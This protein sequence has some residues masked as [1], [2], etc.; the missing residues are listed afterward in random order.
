MGNAIFR[1]H[2]QVHLP[3]LTM[4]LVTLI[5][6]W[7]DFGL[8]FGLW[9][10]PRLGYKGLAWATFASVS[11]GA[12]LNLLIL[13]KQRR[14]DLG[15][16]PNRRWTRRGLPYLLRVAWP[17]GVQQILWHSGYLVVYALTASLP[18]GNIVAL[19]A[20]TAGL[21]LESLLFLPAFAFSMTASIL[22]GHHLGSLD[23]QGARGVA[24]RTWAI[25]CG[26]LTAL[27]AALWPTIPELAAL[28]APQEAVKAVTITY[29]RLNFLALPFTATGMILGGVFNGAGATKYNMQVIG[30]SIWLVRIPCAFV[31]G[32]L[33]LGTATGI[34][35]AMLISQTLQAL[36]MLYLFW[37]K[38]WSRYS[39]QAHKLK[40]NLGTRHA[41]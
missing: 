38:D 7:A 19:A 6:I 31:L 12:G 3:L 16:I 39:L 23:S 25:G 32:H 4:I 34:W 24:W 8:G 22:V 28:L 35:L 29:L 21:R 41:P 2:K 37:S 14:L 15:N 30:G 13:F 26:A 27:T 10:L 1:A 20:L 11:A 18:E 9:G 33:I 40:P 5:N 36:A 17:S